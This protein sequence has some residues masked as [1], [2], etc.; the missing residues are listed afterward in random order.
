MGSAPRTTTGGE[1]PRRVAYSRP[2]MPVQQRQRGY[3]RATSSS[4][5]PAVLPARVGGPAVAGSLLVMAALRGCG[6]GL[7]RD[8]GQEPCAGGQGAGRVRQGAGPPCLHVD[9]GGT[10]E[11]QP[12]EPRGDVLLGAAVERRGAAGGV[13]PGVADPAPRACG[14]ACL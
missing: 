4:S 10:G 7:A 14:R 8:A 6:C 5:G 1:L 2:A 11:G 13:L 3:S 12:V 9:Q